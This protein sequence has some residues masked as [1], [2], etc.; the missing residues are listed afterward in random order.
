[1]TI[2]IERGILSSL[3]ERETLTMFLMDRER[4]THHRERLSALRE[5]KIDNHH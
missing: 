5:G 4:E 3:I 1:M 2:L